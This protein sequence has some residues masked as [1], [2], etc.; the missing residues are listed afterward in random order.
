MRRFPLVAAALFCSALGLPSSA[1]A[2]ARTGPVFITAAGLA[3]IDRAPTSDSASGTLFAAPDSGGTTAGGAFGVGV[4]LTPRVSARLEAQLSGAV[5]SSRVLPGGADPSLFPIPGVTVLR[6]EQTIATSREATPVF[7][8]LGVHLDNARLSLQLVGGLGL[9][10]QTQRTSLRTRLLNGTLP[11]GVNL[12]SLGSE[13]RV[14]DH[15]AVAVVGADAAV[16]FGRHA[17]IVP[18]LRAYV[19]SGSLSLR[20]GVG[21]RWTF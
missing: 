7:A 19:L 1:A 15:H 20:P 10:H 9:V 11:P 21:L 4:H 12:D 17:A 8:L 18:H 3:A 2:Q 6:L 5:K 14:S 16:A 13:V